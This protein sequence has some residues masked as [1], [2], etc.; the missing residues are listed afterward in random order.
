MPVENERP[1][2]G[3]PAAWGSVTSVRDRRSQSWSLTP[4]Q[5]LHKQPSAS[6]RRMLCFLDSYPSWIL[7]SL[8]CK[9]IVPEGPLLQRVSEP[10]CTSEGLGLHAF[11]LQLMEGPV[12]TDDTMLPRSH[13]LGRLRSD[14]M[15]TQ[16]P[17]VAMILWEDAFTVLSNKSARK[18]LE[19][20]LWLAGFAH[21]EMPLTILYV[22]FHQKT[23]LPDCDR[24]LRI[25][26][27]IQGDSEFFRAGYVFSNCF[28][29][30][31]TLAM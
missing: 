25:Q 31:A 30:F 24:H 22:F 14:G 6:S 27:I 20:N 7:G 29:T 15:R 19:D 17:C 1:S 12:V 18:D 21:H 5:D 26:L 16:P 4:L 11:T 23:A 2:S 28:A 8:R 3:M 10:Q 9:I 13:G